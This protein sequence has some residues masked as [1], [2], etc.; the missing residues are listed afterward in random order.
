VRNPFVFFLLWAFVP[1]SSCQSSP[2]SALD[3]NGDLLD[4]A[5]AATYAGVSDFRSADDL[6][7]S[8]EN[9]ESGLF[10]FASATCSH[11]VA[12]ED[13]FVSYVKDTKADVTTFYL[14]ENSSSSYYSAVNKLE[15]YFKTT[16]FD[17]TP[18]MFLGKKGSFS[19]I[20]WGQNTETY[21][22]NA[23]GTVAAFTNI[24]RFGT[25][26]AFEK[27][28]KADILTFFFSSQNAGSADFY[29]NTLYPLAKASG[30]SLFLI[31]DDRLSD[32]D[33]SAICKDLSLT[34]GIYS[35]VVALNGT[36]I[37]VADEN[38]STL[39]RGYYS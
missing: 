16:S 18:T 13:D 1:L 23:V 29:A 11:C 8:F 12:F 35:P 4:Y 30:K 7:A 33:R 25:A 3:R 9:G 36:A 38:A 21:L 5:G 10:F 27:Q 17:S 6:I 2:L 15:T 28:T 26:A 31:D 19:T 37:S 20:S 34:D 32:D 22:K 24:Y 14:T 39:V